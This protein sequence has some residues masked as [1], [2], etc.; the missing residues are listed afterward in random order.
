MGKQGH[1]PVCYLKVTFHGR[2]IP[3][4]KLG[5]VFSESDR[6]ALALSVFLAKISLKTSEDKAK[7]V[8][9]F[10]DPIVSFDDNRVTN[11]IN[12]FKKLQE[13][14]SQIIVLTHYPHFI[15]RFC[16]ITKAAKI[17]CEYLEIGKNDITSSLEKTDRNKFLMSEYGKEFMNIYGFINR[18]HDNCIKTKL[19]PFLECLYLP[20]I[21]AK[22]ICDS[23][24]DC[25]SLENMI[26]GIFANKEEVRT[27]FHS[28]RETLNPDSHIITS[29]NI[30]DVRSFAKEMFE[31]LYDNPQFASI[32][33]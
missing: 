20:M 33:D 2:Q 1:L 13:K 4:N 30:E 18:A 17:R 25:S 32:L 23:N 9:I 31:Y 27:K 24:V 10:D 14:V 21:F 19:R 22:Q 15:K 16:E 6:R 11:S 3:N 12:I 28:F 8:V 7:T 26:D 5:F 29:N